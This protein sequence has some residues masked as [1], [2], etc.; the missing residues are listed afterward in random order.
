MSMQLFKGDCLQIMPRLAD[1]S[2]DI[3]FADLPYGVLGYSWDTMIDLSNLWVQI[4]RIA[5]PDA[6]FIF[7]G[8]QP[9]TSR[10]G[11][12]Q[13]KLLKYGLIW[14]KI[15]RAD[16][17]QARFL[18]MKRHEDILVF[19][20]GNST[21]NPQMVLKNTPSENTAIRYPDSF[22]RFP[23]ETGI[24]PTQK[25]IQLMDWIIKTYSN[26]GNVVLDP[27]MGSGSTGISALCHGRDFIG[28]EMDETYFEI[29]S[30]RLQAKAQRLAAD[31]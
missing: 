4:L 29:A 25:P 13:I 24:H 5:K 10:L 8:Q 7:T 12:S 18:P 19:G 9:F 2:V 1:A 11:M 28:I 30:N 17:F 6:M 3:V 14:E 31:Q 27:V 20:R 23:A 15:N 26:P 21:Y 16:P 22:L